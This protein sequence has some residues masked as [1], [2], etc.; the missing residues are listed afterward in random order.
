MKEKFTIKTGKYFELEDNE[1]KTCQ[2]LCNAAKAVLRGKS[3]YILKC[4]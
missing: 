4:I 3:M 1:N 2:N